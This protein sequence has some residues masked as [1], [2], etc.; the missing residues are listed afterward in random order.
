[1]ALSIVSWD[2]YNCIYDKNGVYDEKSMSAIK[3]PFYQTIYYFTFG[4][5]IKMSCLSG[6]LPHLWNYLQT[7]GIK[8]LEANK[9]SELS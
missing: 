7:T 1:M 8:F 2:I 9:N 3:D 4:H 5:K 6:P